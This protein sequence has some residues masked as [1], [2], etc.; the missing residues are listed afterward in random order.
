M[1]I[2]IAGVDKVLLIYT[3]NTLTQYLLCT[4]SSYVVGLTKP[5][6][7]SHLRITSDIQGYVRLT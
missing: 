5:R 6:E 1:N 7:A 4:T 3:V 2:W